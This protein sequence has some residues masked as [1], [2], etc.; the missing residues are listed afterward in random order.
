[1]KDESQSEQEAIS[2]P[3]PVLNAMLICDLAIREEGTRK[4]SLIGIFE[5][6][7]APQF[8]IHQVLCVYAKLVDAEGEY[9]FRLELVR[10]DDLQILGQGEFRVTFRDRMVP[11]EIVFNFD[12][13]FDHPGRYE[14]R[15]HANNKWVASKSFNVLQMVPSESA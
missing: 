8:P 11:S 7:S 2:A 15:L 5:N 6:I 3:H 1:M 4:V 14:F 12:A 13:G 9:Q 10:I